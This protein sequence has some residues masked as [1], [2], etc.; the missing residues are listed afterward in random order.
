MYNCIKIN[1]YNNKL[2]NQKLMNISTNVES[3]GINKNN[4]DRNEIKNK[5]NIFGINNSNKCNIM[6]S[7]YDK[8]GVFDQ[9]FFLLIEEKNN[10]KFVKEEIENIYGIPIKF[11]EIIYEN[12]KLDDN[13]TIKNLIKG[14]NINET[15]DEIDKKDINM[16]KGNKK[17]K[18]LKEKLKHYG[19]I[20][21]FNEYKKLLEKFKNN[22]IKKDIDVVEFFKS[23][24]K[25]FEKL[26][27]NN[28]ISLEKIKKEIENLK[29]FDKKKLLLR[30]EIDYPHMDN[31]LLI[32]IK[33]LIKF[34]YLGDIQSFL[35]FRV[36]KYI[37]CILSA[38][39]NV[40]II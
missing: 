32:R 33:E 31:L 27:N 10:I 34:Y 35:I 23:F 13:I 1:N 24:D 6:I 16:E 15:D 4:N 17:I 2:A 12:Q 26:L 28:N 3:R 21:L 39:I 38:N 37:I 19:C 29:Y 11:Q 30:L 8:G 18:I 25:E 20:T 7:C 36:D 40:S 5:K 14:K 9:N 22:M